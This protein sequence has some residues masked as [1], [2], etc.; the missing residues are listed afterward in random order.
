MLD[1]DQPTARRIIDAI[2][3]AIDGKPASAKTFAAGPFTELA[4][5]DAWG[6]QNN[7]SSSDTTRTDA[8][9]V[10]Y[11]LFSGGA[12]RSPVSRWM[13]C[14][15]GPISGSLEHSSKKAARKLTRPAKT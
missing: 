7:N 10:A 4:D 14:I 1:L 13:A 6:Q 12:F 11:L 8:L 5:F 2:A 9:T 3:M 15:S